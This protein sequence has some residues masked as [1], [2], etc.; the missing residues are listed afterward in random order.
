MHLAKTESR[1]NKNER[2]IKSN[3]TESVTKNFLLK[4]KSRTR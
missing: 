3:E 1:R 4:L 2:P